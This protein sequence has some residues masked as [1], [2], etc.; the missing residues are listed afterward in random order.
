MYELLLV[1]KDAARRD[2]LVYFLSEAGFRIK[3]LKGADELESTRNGHFDLWIVSDSELALISRE[4]SQ[5]PDGQ[6]E[7]TSTPVLALVNPGDCSAILRT[8]AAGAVGVI[9]RNRS[10]E[11]IVAKVSSVVSDLIVSNEIDVAEASER[12]LEIDRVTHSALISALQSTCEDVTRLQ[13]RYEEELT[14]RHKV[15][16]ALMES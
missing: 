7:S 1:E 5:I 13:R 11:E 14:Q 8:L 4:G 2:S 12:G 6:K 15:E 3:A 10:P 9:S 16:Q